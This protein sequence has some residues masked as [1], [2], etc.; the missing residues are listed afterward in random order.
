MQGKVFVWSNCKPWENLQAVNVV[1]ETPHSP[2]WQQ[3]SHQ[4]CAENEICVETGWGV[5]FRRAW[6]VSI[7][8]FIVLAESHTEKVTGKISIPSHDPGSTHQ[9]RAASALLADKSGPAL[10][11]AEHMALVALGQ[12]FASKQA[13]ALSRDVI[14][15]GKKCDACSHLRLQSLPLRTNTLRATVVMNGKNSGYLFLV[16]IS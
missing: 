8:N 7:T 13:N 14:V 16:T 9:P 10:L 6:C 3:N 2:W 1:C 5:R 4:S 15:G 12:S 11:Q